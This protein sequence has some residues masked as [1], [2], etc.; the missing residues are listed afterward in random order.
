VFSESEEDESDEDEKPKVA[1]RP[2]QKVESGEASNIPCF[3]RLI[4]QQSSL[5]SSEYETD[6]EEEE[7]PKLIRPVFVPK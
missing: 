4:D 1:G 5:Q 6:S 2:I 7:K 3:R